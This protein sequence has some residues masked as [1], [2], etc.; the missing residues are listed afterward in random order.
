LGAAR[1]FRR[2]ER[3]ENHCGDKDWPATLSAPAARAAS[4]LRVFAFIE[5]A[6]AWKQHSV[7]VLVGSSR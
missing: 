3:V 6:G 5:V 7:S 2:F 4:A 1:H